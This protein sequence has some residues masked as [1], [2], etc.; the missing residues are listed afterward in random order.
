[1]GRFSVLIALLAGCAQIAGIEE[2]S[3]TGELPVRLSIQ[4]VSQGATNVYA[5]QDLSEVSATYLVPD[6]AEPDGIR[7]VEAVLTSPNTWGARLETATPILFTVPEYGDRVPRLWDFP[8]PALRG[9]MGV[10]E[11][12]DPQPAPMDAT[13]AVDVALDVPFSNE[14]FQLYTVGA[15]NSRSLSAPATAGDTR[16]APAAFEYKSMTS[17]SGRPHELITT[18]DVVAVLRYA[19]GQLVGALQVPPFDQAVP[20]QSITGSLTTVALDQTLDVRVDPAEVARRLDAV[21]PAVGAPAMSWNLRAAPGGMLNVDQGPTLHTGGSVLVGDAGTITATYGNPFA[22]REWATLLSWTTQGTR[23]YTS[24]GAL[25]IT[26]AAGL[27]QRELPSAGLVL[28]LPAGLPEL[29]KLDGQ[30]L[31]TDGNVIPLP[32]RGVEITF[33]TDIADN[34]MYQLDIFE[35]VPNTASPPTALVRKRVL[36]ASAAAPRFVVPPEL[37]KAGSFYTMRASAIQGGYPTAAM[38]DLTN[39]ELPIAVSFLDSG[40]FQVMP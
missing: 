15:W 2:T 38:G 10:L 22:D 18:Q 33:T 25:P 14:T 29:I 8:T 3:G 16:L 7:R 17:I 21:L 30:A 34:T 32:T 23:T 12:P 4:R 40:V 1:M 9:L 20:A 28:A 24:P 5:P 31:A 39:R 35:L 6:D 37:F 36:G 19:G 26:L 11:H 13:I 27:Y